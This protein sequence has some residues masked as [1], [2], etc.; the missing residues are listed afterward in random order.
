M[1]EEIKNNA[2]VQTHVS[3][4]QKIISRMSNNSSICKITAIVITTLTLTL[5]AICSTQDYYQIARL[6][7]I[8]MWALDCYYL[9]MERIFRIRYIEFVKSIEK[10]DFDFTNIY[11]FET[12]A[13]S[14]KLYH[15]LRGVLSISTTP[16]Y[17]ILSLLIYFSI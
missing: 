1:K 16:Y 3:T 15:V 12:A 10:E 11:K 9:G 2:C 17:L 5:L 8:A 7:L 6:P 14:E 4:M 13:E